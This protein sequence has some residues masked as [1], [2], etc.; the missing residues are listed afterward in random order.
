MVEE[1]N[2]ELVDPSD[3][4]NPTL[5]SDFSLIRVSSLCPFGYNY[6]DCA[7][8]FPEEKKCNYRETVKARLPALTWRKMNDWTTACILMIPCAGTSQVLHSLSFKGSQKSWQM[9]HG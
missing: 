6:N 7:V 3:P 8:L 9:K 1:V 5:Y 2:Q 4:L